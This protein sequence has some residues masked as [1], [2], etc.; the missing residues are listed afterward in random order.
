MREEPTPLERLKR[1]LTIENLWLY[2]I[3]SLI[4][5]GPTYAYDI[6]RRINDEFKIKPAT[7]T[8]YTVIYKL[9]REN[10]LERMSDGTYRVT[11]KG[12]QAYRDAVNFI[13]SILDKL[14]G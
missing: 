11:E 6:K 10:L 4:N 5:N 7:I 2:I 12:M 8:V 13:R 3:A 9:E 1:K 14:P